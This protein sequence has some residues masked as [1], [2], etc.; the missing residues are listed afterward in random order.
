MVTR[1]LVLLSPLSDEKS[2]LENNSQSLS[3]DSIYYQ[4][5]GTPRLL[6][7]FRQHIVLYS[8]VN[9]EDAVQMKRGGEEEKRKRKRHIRHPVIQGP[10]FCFFLSL[11]LLFNRGPAA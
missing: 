6:A 1:T 5:F 10:S 2:G 4:T 3:F 7:I 9:R 11:G 8:R